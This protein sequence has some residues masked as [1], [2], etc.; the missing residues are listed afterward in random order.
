MLI[1]FFHICC[2]NVWNYL[3][4]Q[5]WRH[6]RDLVSVKFHLIFDLITPVWLG[7]QAHSSDL[8]Q[9]ASWL[10]QKKKKKKKPPSEGCHFGVIEEIH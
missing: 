7:L 1:S 6:I 5:F 2:Q 4:S 3:L 10:F 9:N 8:V